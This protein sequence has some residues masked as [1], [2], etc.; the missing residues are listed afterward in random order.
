MSDGMRSR[1]SLDAQHSP[2]QPSRAAAG[3]LYEPTP[4]TTT[5]ITTRRAAA[6]TPASGT[7]PTTSGGLSA[8]PPVAISIPSI[9][10]HSALIR[11]GLN[12]DGSAEVPASFHVAGW[13]ERSVSPGHIGPAIIL[14]HVDSKSGPGIFYRLGALHPGDRVAVTRADGIT[15]TFRITA[16]RSYSK[17]RFPTIDVY[18]NTPAP[19]IRLITC[20]GAFDQATGHYLA[21]VIAFGQLAASP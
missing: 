8:S 19:T 6:G 9:G 17:Q 20:G 10:V 15:A 18:G 4:S 11:L 2:P 14:G 1:S 5:T 16:V 7:S 12:P 3:S 13:Y 21:N